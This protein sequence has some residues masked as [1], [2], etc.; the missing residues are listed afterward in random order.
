MTESNLPLPW[1]LAA[2][3]LRTAITLVVLVGAIRVFGKRDMG[4]LNLLDLLMVLLIG[5]AVQNALT[6][7][8]GSLA[9][10]LT[11]AGVLLLLDRAQGALFTRHP[12]IARRLEGE[13]T[14]LVVDGRVDRKA[15]DVEGVSEDAIYAAMHEQGVARLDAVR[16]A[17]LEVN[18]T[19]SIVPREHPG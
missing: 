18:G 3:A 19:I 2:I 7:G 10:A 12:A 16:V 17:V 15:L 11:S 13:P 4:G 14:V 5:N 8:S 9:G 1:F 6:Q